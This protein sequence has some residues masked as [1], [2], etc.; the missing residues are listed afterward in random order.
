[1]PDPCLTASRQTDTGSH[2]H[3][4]PPP[5][6]PASECVP[7]DHQAASRVPGARRSVV[8]RCRRTQGRGAGFPPQV[9]GVRTGCVLPSPASP[10]STPPHCR[11]AAPGFGP[12]LVTT[13]RGISSAAPAAARR[14]RRR[15][16]GCP[17]APE[18][19]TAL[20]RRRPPR[21]ARH[22]PRLLRILDSVENLSNPGAPP[23][24]LFRRSTM[25]KSGH[26]HRFGPRA[27]LEISANGRLLVAY[28]TGSRSRGPPHVRAAP[29]HAHTGSSSTWAASSSRRLFPSA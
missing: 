14:A 26:V 28:T 29:L 27:G 11:R 1:M 24:R 7:V 22:A 20:G 15:Q 3:V 9:I 8:L 5:S 16:A 2:G 10:T 23:P 18:L 17:V 6:L 25:F 21:S 13:A 12:E 4:E 19:T